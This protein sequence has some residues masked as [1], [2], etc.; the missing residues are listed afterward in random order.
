LS[1]P[2]TDVFLLVFSV[3]NPNSFYNARHKWIPEAKRHCPTVP[4]ILCGSKIDLRE[5][6]DML[7]RLKQ[8]NQQ[9]VT[10]E[11]GE[12][13]AWSCDCIGYV[14][15]SALTQ[16]NLKKTFDSIIR[17]SG[18]WSTKRNQLKKEKAK[19]LNSACKSQ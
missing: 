3:V 13:M 11:E 14:E 4:I 18:A 8:T 1:Y 15:N 5:D 9:V 17:C 7:A 6:P 12:Y 19:K 2:G 16:Q 10:A